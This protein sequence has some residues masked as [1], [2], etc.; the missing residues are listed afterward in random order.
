[1]AVVE[2]AIDQPAWGQVRV[3]NELRSRGLSISRSA[4]GFTTAPTSRSG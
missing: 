4:C 3:S 1:M 2:L